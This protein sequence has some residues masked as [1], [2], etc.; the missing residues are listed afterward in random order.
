MDADRG[1]KTLPQEAGRTPRNQR[2]SLTVRAV[3]TSDFDAIVQLGAEL[4]AESA[5]ASL[6][7]DADKL[8]K[9]MDWA[10]TVDAYMGWVAYVG[11]E[12]VGAMG[13]CIDQYFF[14]NLLFARDV[15]MFVKEEHRTA[16]P[17]AAL[18]LVN[19]F[20]K[21]ARKM[22]IQEIRLS[23][24]TG[25]KPEKMQRFYTS[26]GYEWTGTTHMKRV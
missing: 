20:E 19:L 13:G 5:Y 17:L 6:P 21:W 11:D 1:I 12:L 25:Y 14:C 9:A 10:V 24:T 22:P 16:R 15:F 3:Q 8:R 18:R 7:Y 4:H 26:L 2:E 23:S